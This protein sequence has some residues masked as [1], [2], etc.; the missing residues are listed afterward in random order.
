M[1]ALAFICTPAAADAQAVLGKAL[2]VGATNLG[3]MRLL[4]EAHTSAFGH[5]SPW[6]VSTTP[7]PG[8]ALLVTG[9]DLN[10]LQAVLTQTAGT[11][12]SV[13]T[14]GEMLPAHGYPELRN[15][16][17]LAGHYGGAWY[18]QKVDFKHF[19]GAIIA[20]TNCVLEPP[21]GTYA[22][23]L[24]TTGETGVVS[25]L[26]CTGR[27]F[28]KAIARAQEL[29]GFS[30]DDVEERRG[31]AEHLVGFGRETM[32]GTAPK[33]LEAIREGKLSHTFLIGGCDGMEGSRRYY[34]RVAEKMPDC[35]IVLTLGCA[36]F[37]L[38]DTELCRST[39]PGTELPRLLDMGQCNVRRT[40]RA[41]RSALR[42]APSR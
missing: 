32:L 8:K 13:Y 7:R 20:T 33:V 35:A 39:V 2:E 28:S 25:V 41:P 40:K 5:P 27:D 31:G 22:D 3:V 1:R 30:A 14:H 16:A 4:E 29:P 18:W 37:R 17:H 19:P 11:G 21:E 12:I 42:R 6:K 36:K 15:H 34:K 23:N 26:H 38:L 9:H 10:D 24:F